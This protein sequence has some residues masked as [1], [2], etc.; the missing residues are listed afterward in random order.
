MS[1]KK[2]DTFIS[3]YC[4]AEDAVAS[5]QFPGGCRWLLAEAQLTEDLWTRLGVITGLRG[6]RC[7][8]PSFQVERGTSAGHGWARQGG[9]EGGIRLLLA[10]L[11]GTEGSLHVP[12]S[13]NSTYLFVSIVQV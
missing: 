7:R 6:P 8:I 2:L 12:E 9:K 3:T 1:G 11:L 4:C 13:R 5:L 10:L